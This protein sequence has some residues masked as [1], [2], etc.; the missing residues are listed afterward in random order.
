MMDVK[1]MREAEIKHGRVSMLAILGFTYPEMPWAVQAFPGEAY[2]HANPIVAAASVP[3][4][5][6]VQI[7]FFVGVMEFGLNKEKMTMMDMFEDKARVPGDY[8]FDPLQLMSPANEERMK[9]RELQHCRVAMVG[10]LG[11][12]GTSLVSGHG[13]FGSST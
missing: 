1:F 6:F 5:A 4:G 8:G 7:L 3:L 13:V 12:I 11:M 2:S 9:M 10:I